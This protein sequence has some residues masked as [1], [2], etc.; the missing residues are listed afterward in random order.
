MIFAPYHA[1]VAEALDARAKKKQPTV[2]VSVHSFTPVY[3]G[4]V[5]EMHA[6]VLYHRE[7]A[8]AVPMLKAMRAHADL[9]IGDNEP[10][11][12]S[13]A[14]DYAIPVHGEQRG[15]PHVGLEIR[16]D[17]IATPA[18]QRIW[19]KRIADALRVAITEIPS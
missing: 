5:R 13:L 14:T 18:N 15:L 4:D 6:A 10:Y 17:L 8:L 7:K 1:A 3:K 19:G 16:Q 9:I 12:A 11:A 2:L